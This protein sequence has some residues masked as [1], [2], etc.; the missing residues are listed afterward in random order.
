MIR[1]RDPRPALLITA[2]CLTLSLLALRDRFDAPQ[3]IEVEAT[4]AVVMIAGR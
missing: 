2:V 3:R 1:Q 4:P